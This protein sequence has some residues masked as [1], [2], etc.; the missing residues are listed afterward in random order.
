MQ[1]T[2]KKKERITSAKK[3][4]TSLRVFGA[5]IEKN[6]V[7]Q[8]DIDDESIAA[9]KIMHKVEVFLETWEIK[10]NEG[11]CLSRSFLNFVL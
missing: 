2:K 4:N 7:A 3:H 5:F 9:D 11:N 1:G 8:S 6:L 10:M